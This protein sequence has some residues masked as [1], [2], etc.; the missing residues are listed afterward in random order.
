MRRG[1]YY[2][3]L[4]KICACVLLYRYENRQV[5]SSHNLQTT[6]LPSSK[7][8]YLNYLPPFRLTR[9]RAQIGLERCWL[10]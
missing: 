5:T 9:I 4:Q 10:P 6:F 8:L 2:A 1:M 3:S 7:T